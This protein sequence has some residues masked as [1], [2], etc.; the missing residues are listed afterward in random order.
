M[1]LWKTREAVHC[2][3]G[4]GSSGEIAT[5]RGFQV[6]A[7][8]SAWKRRG[9]LRR[10]RIFVLSGIKDISGK[11]VLS[12]WFPGRVGKWK[13]Y[14]RNK[15]VLSNDAKKSRSFASFAT[16]EQDIAWCMPLKEKGCD[17]DVPVATTKHWRAEEAM[18]FA[19]CAFG[20]MMD[21]MITEL[22]LFLAAP[23][24]G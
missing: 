21:K 7:L 17:T 3:R 6:A 10:G 9:K 22:A 5:N 24:M 14:S 20:K 16:W 23:I 4:R 19:R 2:R 18:I 15:N 13:N 8:G 12:G 11:V 1:P